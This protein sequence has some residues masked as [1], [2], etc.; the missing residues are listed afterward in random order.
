MKKVTIDLK[1]QDVDELDVLLF[2]EYDACTVNNGQ[3]TLYSRKACD[4]KQLPSSIF[5]NTPSPSCNSL[6]TVHCNSMQSDLF[7][8]HSRADNIKSSVSHINNMISVNML[9][10]IVMCMSTV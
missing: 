6:F 5:I 4:I 1:D 3:I 7:A 10:N 8:S 9:S 2:S